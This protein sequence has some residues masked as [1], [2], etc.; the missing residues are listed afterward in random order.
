MLK[1]RQSDCVETMP[2]A[3]LR[4]CDIRKSGASSLVIEGHEGQW[5]K[6][7]VQP[8]SRAIRQTGTSLTL[9]ALPVKTKCS[10]AGLKATAKISRS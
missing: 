7:S 9:S 1:Q 10:F 5:S 3:R 4:L 6:G 2:S 8:V